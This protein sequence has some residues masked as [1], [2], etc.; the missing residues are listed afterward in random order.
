MRRSRTPGVISASCFA[1]RDAYGSSAPATSSAAPDRAAKDRIAWSACRPR[2]SD[3][4]ETSASDR[5]AESAPASMIGQRRAEVQA[6]DAD[7]R[8]HHIRLPFQPVH[9]GLDVSGER[10][11]GVGRNRT[12][13]RAMPSQIDREDAEAGLVQSARHD[14]PVSV[15]AHVGMHQQHRG[16]RGGPGRPTPP[17]GSPRRRCEW[18]PSLR[19]RRRGMPCT[20]R[21][22]AQTAI[23]AMRVTRLILRAPPGIRAPR[24]RGRRRSRG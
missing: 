6:G 10:L 17:P 9:R 5:T 16:R 11:Q 7:V 3:A 2:N 13:R 4:G 18:T 24:D 8:R 1:D 12:D 14:I 22:Q 21:R 15:R 23:A 19:H 20:T